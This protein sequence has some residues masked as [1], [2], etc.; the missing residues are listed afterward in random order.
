MDILLLCQ[1]EQIQQE[2][3]LHQ[4]FSACHG[5]TAAFVEADIPLVLY[6]GSIKVP[7]FI[8]QVSGL[9]QYAQRMGHPCTNT[10]NLTPGPSTVPKLS[11]ECILPCIS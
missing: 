7:P 9:W 4:W 5:D 11:K 2:I 1:T 6:A 10:T 8:S 3:D